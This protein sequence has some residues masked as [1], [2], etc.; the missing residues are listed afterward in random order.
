MLACPRFPAMLALHNAL[1]LAV[2]RE[3]L[4]YLIVQID[5]NECIAGTIR[6]AGQEQLNLTSR[7]ISPREVVSLEYHDMREL[8]S[9]P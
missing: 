2:M 6:A 3:A 7:G 9:T 5:L 1:M 4:Q 8:Q